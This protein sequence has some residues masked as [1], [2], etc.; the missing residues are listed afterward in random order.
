M[1]TLLLLAVLSGAAQAAQPST[2]AVRL[3]YF[4]GGRTGLFYR[5]CVNGCFAAAGIRLDLYSR[6]GMRDAGFTRIPMGLWLDDE[7]LAKASG[8]DIVDRIAAGEL[9]GGTIGEASFLDAVDRGQPIV[10]V[11]LL[12][13]QTTDNPSHAILIRRGLEIRSPEDLK[14]KTL[15]S[16]KAGPMDEALLR[17]F[18]RQEGLDPDKD[19]KILPQVYNDEAKSLLIAGKVD[20]GLYHLLAAKKLIEKKAAYLYRPMDWADPGM[21]QALLVFH[22][23]YLRRN[24]DTVRRI[25]EAYT[26]RIAFER[27]IPEEKKDRSFF[28]GLMMAGDFEGLKVPSHSLP[29]RVRLE[30]LAQAQQ[31]LLRSGAL[32][33]ASKL[34]PFIDNRFVDQAAAALAA[35]PAPRACLPH[36]LLPFQNILLI[37]WAGA[38]RA[39]VRRQMGLGQLRQLRELSEDGAFVDIAPD[40]DRPGGSWSPAMLKDPL[41]RGGIATRDLDA[42][43]S[44]DRL[45]Q[46]RRLG[47][48]R[49]LLSARFRDPIGEAD[50]WLGRITEVMRE[51][52]LFEKTLIYVIGEDFLA[53]NDR[54]VSAE[55][56]RLQDIATT[57][58]DRFG[59]WPR[60]TPGRAE[61]RS[62]LA[63]A[64]P[65]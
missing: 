37:R 25:V 15:I 10:A 57:L 65:R 53:T 13:H 35:D 27:A 36:P 59:A 39:G 52:K 11:A 55:E 5:V 18:V 24:P 23:D 38:S 34:E 49:F 1:R 32:K 47:A 20:G 46:I 26:R 40:S 58:L 60:S 17:E 50:V 16:R 21:L 64:P 61:G 31:L 8:V 45:A 54:A 33:K 29:P 6:R 41:G 44:Q 7:G 3:G 30:P 48:G 62:L 9:D 19:V 56:G 4:H 22:K 14:G 42:D 63:P 51:R 12:G 2:A 43:P 28:R